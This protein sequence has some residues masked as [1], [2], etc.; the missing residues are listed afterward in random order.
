MEA[1]RPLF[2]RFDQQY[3]A[4]LRELGRFPSV[5]DALGILHSAA[6]ENGELRRRLGH[7]LDSAHSLINTGDETLVSA[8]LLRGLEKR[9][10]G[11][12]GRIN[13]GVSRVVGHFL[14]LQEEMRKR[15]FSYGKEIDPK[16]VALINA[17]IKKDGRLIPLL[18]AD[19]AQHLREIER[20]AAPKPTVQ[21]ERKTMAINGRRF[22]AQLAKAANWG[23][24]TEIEDLSFKILEPGQYKK[25][26]ENFPRHNRRLMADL[27]QRVRDAL[28]EAGI[29]ARVQAR[30]KGKYRVYQTLVDKN[31]KLRKE[32]AR[33]ENGSKK[34]LL[35]P[36]DIGDLI[37]IRVITGSESEKDLH[38]ARAIV[39]EEFAKILKFKEERDYV[40]T[41]KE[42]GYRAYHDRY[43]YKTP[44][45]PK[46]G[47]EFQFRTF[48]DHW[49]AEVG[50]P[51][52]A[53]KFGGMHNPPKELETQI[54]T[55]LKNAHRL[56]QKYELGRLAKIIPDVEVK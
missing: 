34:K 14:E 52:F 43:S 1:N 21:D 22:W 29:N 31:G 39:R 20:N 7:Y 2:A 56:Y 18:V 5:Q 26:S 36:Q 8:M 55:L 46:Q 16:F 51:H 4:K 28:S 47:V 11:R 6:G 27:Q 15:G 50:L 38:K 24:S 12:V 13:G 23:V 10:L 53:Y 19:F 41:P 17:K 33:L 30:I 45:L 54:G 35:T 48:P 25:I 37:G 32:N 40:S 42:S 3:R 9:Q 44:A 49:K